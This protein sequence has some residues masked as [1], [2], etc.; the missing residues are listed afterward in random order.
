MLD[1]NAT[2][3]A[4]TFFGDKANFTDI[5]Y[6]LLILLLSYGFVTY[7]NS[8]LRGTNPRTTP[9]PNGHSIYNEEEDI[10][11]NCD[12]SNIKVTKI[13]VHPIKVCIIEA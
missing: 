11:L 8:R 9:K 2:R 7:Y 10:L 1:S 4:Q 6:P 5:Y 12:Y 13:L 3:L